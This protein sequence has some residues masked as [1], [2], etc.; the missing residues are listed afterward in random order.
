M[1]PPEDK[2]EADRAAE[3][4]A[5]RRHDVRAPRVSR[6]TKDS[7]KFRA[8]APRPERP[9]A[10]R[11]RSP[12][13]NRPPPPRDRPRQDRPRSG[14]PRDRAP[15]PRDRDAA[16]RERDRREEPRPEKRADARFF[17]QRPARTSQRD[18]VR[19]RAEEDLAARLEAPASADKPVS[20]VDKPSVVPPTKP[21]SQ[22][23][24]PPPPTKPPTVSVIEPAPKTKPAPSANEILEV[25]SAKKVTVV[26]PK[27]DK[28]KTAKEAMR[29]RAEAEQSKRG[30]VVPKKADKK[31]K[32]ASNAEKKK[33]DDDDDDPPSLTKR[34][35]DVAR[36]ADPPAKLGFWGRVKRL[37]GR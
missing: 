7:P 1:I 27:K 31:P 4:P 32:K 10:D 21:A 29:L 12:D 24:A 36:A 23:S 20:R 15:A 2:P 33:K 11:H 26:A 25:A 34:S 3:K 37:L 9:P 16:P 30:P 19:S 18:D 35:E 17:P 5:P 28:P 6:S 8:D 22:D 14:P 13:E